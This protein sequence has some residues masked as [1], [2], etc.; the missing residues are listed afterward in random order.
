[1]AYRIEIAAQARKEIVAL[2][3]AVLRRVDARILSLSDNPR[4]HGVKKLTGDEDFY[5]VRVGEYRIVY[6][7]NDKVL[8]VLIVRVRHRWKV[9]Q[10]H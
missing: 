5:R 10:G 9:Y 8:L 1:M 4:P 6:Q 3:K 7:I 2:P